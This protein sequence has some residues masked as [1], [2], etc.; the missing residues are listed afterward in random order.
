[1]GETSIITINNA[2]YAGADEMKGKYL[3]FWADRQLFGIPIATVVQIVG[4]QKITEIPE[5]PHYAKG[6]INLR[7]SIIPVIDIRIRLGKPETEYNDRTCIIVVNIES[8]SENFGFIVDGVEEVTNIDDEQISAPPQVEGGFENQYVT[9]VARQAVEDKGAERIILLMDI[10][11]ILG[12][13]DFN[14]LS[15]AI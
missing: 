9:G 3:T 10:S 13:E 8:S 7:G 2:L 4:M 14:A 11:K 12:R 6:I 1:M 15:S 5:Y